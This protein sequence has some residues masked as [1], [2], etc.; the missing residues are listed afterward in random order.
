MI[1]MVVLP[2]AVRRAMLA[3]VRG[4]VAIRVKTIR[5]RAEF[6]WRSP[7]RLRRWRRCLPEEASTGL[8][9]HKRYDDQD[10]P[11]HATHLT[12]PSTPNGDLEDLLQASSAD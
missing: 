4:S 6:A 2:A 1:S 8:A 7:P 5:Q 11:D 10:T 12:A 9:P 3:C